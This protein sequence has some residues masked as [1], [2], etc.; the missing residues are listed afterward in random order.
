[1]SGAW[2]AGATR[3]KALVRR[4]LGEAGA[5]RLARSGS[6]EAAVETLSTGPYGHDVRPGLD[7]V[8]AQ[9]AV[10]AT[11]LW[12]T[13][14]L[15]GWVPRQGADALRM[16]ARWFEIANVDALLAGADAP[17]ELG[18]LATSW[19]RLSR[20]A[21]PRALRAELASSAWGD[22][23]GDSPREIQL[24]MRLSW[25]ARVADA[26]DP[27]L[28]WAAGAA[29][30][31]VARERFLQRRELSPRTSERAAA[32]LGAEAADAPSLADLAGRLPVAAAWALDEVD[33]P[34]QLWRG[35]VRCWQRIDHD[36]WALLAGSGFGLEP[37]IGALAV[38]AADAWRT[39]AALAR[40]ARGV[41][42]EDAQA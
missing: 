38:L 14:V 21:D 22:P 8:Q 17:F 26:L 31:L 28:P 24:G 41:R 16:L 25:A 11:L 10:A 4:R 29:A 35:E 18:A 6:F 33:E 3:A 15:A 19:S 2:V 9:H 23:G 30:L 27:A 37:V 42:G 12:H 20:A 40:L 32:L 7:P 39:R 36:G 1:M 5:V 13:R 34:E